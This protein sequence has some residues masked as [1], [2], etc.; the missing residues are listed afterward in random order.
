VSPH[1]AIAKVLGFLSL[2]TSLAALVVIALWSTFT[3]RQAQNYAG[4]TDDDDL[5]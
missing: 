1:F 2:Q 3:A 4:V 5:D